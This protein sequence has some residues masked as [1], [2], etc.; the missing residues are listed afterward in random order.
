MTEQS[1]TDRG[2]TVDE[3]EAAVDEAAAQQIELRTDIPHSARI[4]DYLLGG[5][6]N[7]APDRAAAEMIVQNLPHLA[8]SMR[9]NRRFLARVAHHLA[10]D[11]GIRQF[12]DVGTGLPTSP[13]LH[14]VVQQVAPESRV[15]YVDNDPIVL[16]HARALLTSSPQGRTSYL[17]ADLWHPESILTAPQVVTTLDLAEPVAVSLLAVLQFVEDD[18]DA[19]RIIAELMAPMPPGSV[20]AVSTATSDSAP[21]E[22]ARGAIAY[23]SNGIPSR[24]RTRA[25]VEA[26]LT[27]FDL[28]EPGVT[29]VHRWRPGPA[30]AQIPDHQVYMYGAAAI[31]R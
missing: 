11:L 31:K 21:D 29:L 6:D 3:A 1:Q 2:V 19:R 26:L 16:V 22:V 25:E 28:V 24:P 18:E 20:L 9:A 14:E 15:V 8:V 4:Y 30:D 27:G 12:L 23:K 13:N 10:A 17:D 5:K 7:Y